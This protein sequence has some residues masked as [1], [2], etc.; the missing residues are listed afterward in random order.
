MTT[1]G[2]VVKLAPP[3]VH[4]DTQMRSNQGM[5]WDHVIQ[6]YMNQISMKSGMEIFGTRGV[7]TVSNELKNLH[8]L[9]SF[10]PL[11]L[12]KIIKEEY[13]EVLQYHLFIK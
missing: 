7:D 8:L 13:G 3:Y 4:P 12:H 2:S 5:D 6:Y 10:E 9:K 11:E 1:V